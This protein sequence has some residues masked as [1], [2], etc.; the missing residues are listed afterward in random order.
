MIRTNY[1]GSFLCLTLCMGAWLSGCASKGQ[2]LAQ[3]KTTTKEKIEQT[4]Q[5]VEPTSPIT[6]ET[7]T[8]EVSPTHPSSANPD[9]TAT[10]EPQEE[11]IKQGMFTSVIQ[12]I[13]DN[14]LTLYWSGDQTYTFYIGGLMEAKYKPGDGLMIREDKDD[15]GLVCNFSDEGKL[16]TDQN[17]T[18]TSTQK[19]KCGDLMFALDQQLTD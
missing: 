10:P 11:D 15:T 16:S 12:K 7:Q 5:I 8:T 3:A 18:A 1:L 6:N 17:A 13:G 14:P 2:E 9:V 4:V 19:Q